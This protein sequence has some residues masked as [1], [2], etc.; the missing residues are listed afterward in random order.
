MD[1]TE[2]IN[3]SSEKMKGFHKSPNWLTALPIAH[4]GLHRDIAT[5]EN[6][7]SAFEA[8]VNHGY[9]IECDVQLLADGTPI[10]FHDDDGSRMLGLERQIRSM[11]QPEIKST[12]LL[13]TKERPPALEEVLNVVDGR[14]PL[15]LDI[16]ANT[17]DQESLIT[18][19]DCAL[20]NY[21]GQVAFMSFQLRTLRLLHES[22]PK[23]IIGL[24]GHGDS[25][26][27]DRKYR[28]AGHLSVSFIA[29]KSMHLPVD[30]VSECRASGVPIIGWTVRSD[31]DQLAALHVCD[32]II[33]EAF[34]P[35][36]SA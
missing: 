11:T 27:A 9:A 24:A 16:K 15:F 33:F 10:V 34:E 32:Q 25:A 29:Y 6:S 8:A 19:I 35:W 14:V 7:L 13:G 1:V 26:A 17:A 18:A 5:P 20:T 21:R 30:W 36:K 4:R 31:E 12:N 3:W 28:P 2:A 22:R 23:R